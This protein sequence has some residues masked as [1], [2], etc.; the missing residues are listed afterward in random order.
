MHRFRV[1]IADKVSKE[2]TDVLR[3]AQVPFDVKTGL[4]E[5]QLSAI[6]GE[7]DAMVVRSDTQVTKRVFENGTRLRVVAR[8]G[9]GVDN[10]DLTEA[11]SRGV[12]VVNSPQGNT[13]AAAEHTWAMT[14]RLARGVPIDKPTRA[15][16]VA[17]KTLGVL[18]FGNIGQ[19]VASYAKGMGMNIIA[20][21]PFVKPEV[22]AKAGATLHDAE[23]VL[24]NS[25][26]VTLHLPVTKDTRR[27]LNKARLGMMRK[28]ALLV[29]VSRGEVIDT[30]ALLEALA[31]GHL[32][33]A[34]LDVFE[35]E[36][37][38]ADSQL[39]KINNVVLTPHL[40]ASTHEAQVKVAIDVCEQIVDVMN[41]RPART[42]VNI[43]S[44]QPSLIEPVRKYIT[45]VEKL[46]LIVGQ[47]SKSV[48]QKLEIEFAGDAFTN[49]NVAPL[50]TTMMKGL[51]TPIVGSGKVNFVNADIHARE[52]GLSV[53]VIKCASNNYRS[54]ITVRAIGA[55]TDMEIAGTVFEGLGDRIVYFNGFTIDVV[56]EG[57]LLFILYRDQIGIVGTVGTFL[58]KKNIN[59]ATMEVGRLVR[60]GAAVMVLQVDNA[61]SE[62]TLTEL[63]SNYKDIMSTAYSV[64]LPTAPRSTTKRSKL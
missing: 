49:V 42:A 2:G 19:M 29:N 53:E 31:S 45:L 62:N 37:L 28:G 51:L 50:T 25:D 27:F 41:G 13:V 4:N 21:D 58:G 10:V 12:I 5:E 34:A 61:I 16:Q 47:L 26:I 36:P 54:L 3:N 23:S 35:K 38:E 40:G 55:D 48:I 56:P 30:P 22:A 14:L 20:Y 1:L 44:M 39:R 63:T 18:G 6:I 17:G 15:I 57:H 11:T 9:V 52:R 64:H 43:P 33:G 24:K 60:G 7:Y 59:I 32:G 8:A 46:G